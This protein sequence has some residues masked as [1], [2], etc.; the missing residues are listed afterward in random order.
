[1]EATG[2]LFPPAVQRPALTPR[3]LVVLRHLAEGH[4]LS[5]IAR[6]LG[7][8]VNTIKTQA[9]SLYR[10]LGASTRRQAVDAAARE[11]FL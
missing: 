11:G 1:M 10:K 5:D 9:S 3:E 8:S 4:P 7:L 6:D 2:R